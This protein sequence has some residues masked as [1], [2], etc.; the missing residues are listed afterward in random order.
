MKKLIYISLFFSFFLGFSGSTLA[1][2]PPFHGNYSSFYYDLAPY[3][4][5]I[6]LSPDVVVWR[7][8]TNMS[9]AP[10]S[11]G[12]W[13]WTNY[14]WYWDS[15]EPFGYVVF[16]Y[17]RWFYDD[18]Y[19]WVWL[20]D[21]QWAPAWVEWRYDNSYIGWSPL[22]PYAFFS[23]N[24]GLYW[25]FNYVIPYNHWH[26]VNVHHFHHKN[27][28]KYFV[29]DKIK[30]RTY[31][32]TKIRTRYETRN[33]S[34]FNRGV[35]PGDLER[36]TNNRFRENTVTLR[37]RSGSTDPVVRRDNSIEI[38]YRPDLSREIKDRNIESSTRK[39]TLDVER[40][41]ERK[42]VNSNTESRD[43]NT[44]TTQPKI[45]TRERNET[46]TPRIETRQRNETTPPQIE[47]RQRNETNTPR[48]E[49][50]QRNE[51]TPPQIETRQRNETTT[52]QIE[53]RQRNEN[54][55]PKIETRENNSKREEKSTNRNTETRTRQR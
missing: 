8:R 4:R 15:Y 46:T 1:A 50:R 9:W 10:Y 2:N 35:D 37:D 42:D 32:N 41:R 24:S 11:S 47:T 18:Y 16:H 12:R 13:I 29:G 38:N 21:D 34:V 23:N 45:E 31:N 28:N 52:P 6:E 53:T 49:T 25:S 30:Y 55:Q 20:P 22:P 36:I 5:W 7:P 17:G 3:G 48:I 43:R 44:Q 14:G 51:T 19:G 39:S 27:I 33:N 54:S 26:F 40:I